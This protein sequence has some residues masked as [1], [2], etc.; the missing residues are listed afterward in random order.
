MYVLKM[1]KTFLIKNADEIDSQ[2]TLLMKL[3]P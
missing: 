2:W 3:L 1:E